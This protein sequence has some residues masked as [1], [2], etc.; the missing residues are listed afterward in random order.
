MIMGW[1]RNVSPMAADPGTIVAVPY[2]STMRSSVKTLQLGQ[3]DHRELPLITGKF[4]EEGDLGRL[5]YCS[6]AASHAWM[7]LQF[8]WT[9]RNRKAG[10]LGNVIIS[11]TQN[12]RIG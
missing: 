11:R 7:V 6:T 2:T 8:D 10:K 12:C 1:A 4:R 9:A 5:H 3:V